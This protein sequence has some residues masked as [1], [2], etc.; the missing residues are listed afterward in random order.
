MEA[1]WSV[2]R[3]DVRYIGEMFSIMEK[4]PVKSQIALI[5]TISTIGW[6]G[7]FISLDIITAAGSYH[8]N[9]PDIKI[10]I[11]GDVLNKI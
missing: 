9:S 8:D 1:P 4:S 10:F 6:F 5:S 2:L 3:E 7:T 11:V